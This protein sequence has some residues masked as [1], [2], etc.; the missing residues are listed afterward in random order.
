MG[1]IMPMAFSFAPYGWMSCEGQLL[2]ISQYSAVF[3]LL[4]T[5]Y[6]GNGQTTFQLPDLRGRMIIGQGTGPGLPT[7]DVGEMGGAPQVTLLISQMPMHTHAIVAK[8]NGLSSNSNDPNGNYFGGGTVANYDTA[9]DNSSVLNPQCITAGVAGGS[10]PVG[11]MNPY[12][13]MYYNI[14]MQGIFPTRN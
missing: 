2:P 4:G 10:Q 5:M 14:C 8:A 3:A 11:I 9:Q 1:S 13:A 7:Y 6:G 12:V